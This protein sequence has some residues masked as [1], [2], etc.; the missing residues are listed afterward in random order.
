[1]NK[2]QS[3]KFLKNASRAEVVRPAPSK[4][5]PSFDSRRLDDVNYTR[6]KLE[7]LSEYNKPFIVTATLTS[8]NDHFYTFTDIRP[9]IEKIHPCRIG[10]LCDHVNIQVKDALCYT[11]YQALYEGVHVIL[12]CEVS[13]YYSKYN[14]KRYGIV[15]TNKLKYASILFNRKWVKEINKN[16]Y[17]QFTKPILS[18]LNIRI[19][20][21]LRD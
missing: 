1:M 14:E 15:L 18:K 5:L 11:D 12:L 8:K 6:T 13:C 16:D 9:Y 7:Q 4:P 10:Q 3:K 19:K 20:P 21:M 17:L 2:T